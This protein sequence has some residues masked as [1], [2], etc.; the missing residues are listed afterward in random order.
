MKNRDL[1]TAALTCGAGVVLIGIGLTGLWSE[2]TLQPGL[3]PSRW[4]FLLP[5]A[6]GC[7][8]LAFKRAA[9]LLTLGVGVALLMVDAALGGSVAMILVFFDLLYTASLLARPK[10]RVAL[11]TGGALLTVVPMAYA[12]TGS[13]DLRMVTLIGL[14]QAALYLCP[15]WWAMDV[16]RKSELADVAAARADAVESLAQVNQ[17]RAV[18]AERD[19]LARDLHDVVASHLSA[20]ALHSG[21]ALATEADPI[22]DRT[23][24]EQVRRSALESMTEMQTMIAL[25]RSPEEVGPDAG[26]LPRLSH[27]DPLLSAARANGLAVTLK[28]QRQRD[29]A[30]AAVELVGYRIVQE[31]LT[32]AA[33]HARGSAVV[34]AIRDDDGEVILTVRNTLSEY[35][36]GASPPGLGMGMG[37]MEE[38]AL[39]IGGTVK[40]SA[41]DDSWTVTAVLPV[42]SPVGVGE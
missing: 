17:Q 20:I 8:A 4:W 23:A 18:R 13:A 26:A 27:L 35:R 28:D 37:T 33:K 40:V 6:V 10:I 29:D 38:R 32:N 14:Q 15:Q 41:E 22:K 39:A 1:R 7:V 12:F 2:P 42:Q 36:N 25:L 11:W 24:L 31:A 30:G 9:P 34:V 16:R 5:L 21:G 3:D 19:A